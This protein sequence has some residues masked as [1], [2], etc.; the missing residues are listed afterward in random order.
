LVNVEGKTRETINAEYRH[1]V[2]DACDRHFADLI[3]ARPG[4]DNLYRQLFRA[5]YGTVAVWFYCP[6]DVDAIEGSPKDVRIGEKQF[7]QKLHV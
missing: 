7:S 2:A 3:P 1:K 6:V 4:K 5:I